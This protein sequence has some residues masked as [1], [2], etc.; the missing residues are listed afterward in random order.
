[1]LYSEKDRMQLMWRLFVGAVRQSESYESQGIEHAPVPET[2]EDVTTS[3]LSA[4]Q[5]ANKLDDQED[6]NTS[7]TSG[8]YLCLYRHKLVYRSCSG[9]EVAMTYMWTEI[10]V[11]EDHEANLYPLTEYSRVQGA[12]MGLEDKVNV[13]ENHIDE[14]TDHG[15]VHI[16]LK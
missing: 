5:Y 14:W 16:S 7:I 8:D 4:F 2:W 6:N 15:S 1:M 12:L 3:V 10:H 9:V 13:T 11:P